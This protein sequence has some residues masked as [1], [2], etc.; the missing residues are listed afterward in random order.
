MPKTGAVYKRELIHLFQWLRAGVDFCDLLRHLLQPSIVWIRTAY[1]Y[2][3]AG[4]SDR[5]VK[6]GDPLSPLL[7]NIYLSVVQRFVMMKYRIW[8][9]SK[10]EGHEDEGRVRECLRASDSD[11]VDVVWDRASLG[12]Y[13][14]LPVWYADNGVLFAGSLEVLSAAV[15]WA[16]EAATMLQLKFNPRKSVLMRFLGRDR[17]SASLQQGSVRLQG[18]DLATATETRWL[19]FTVTDDL[20]LRRH[21]ELRLKAAKVA[22][23]QFMDMGVWQMGVSLRSSCDTVEDIGTTSIIVR[24]GGASCAW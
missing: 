16:D 3:N 24:C 15:S 23:R 12:H 22:H 14:F 8:L 17:T 5:G 4:V 9:L 2:V 19:G 7:F 13:C 18:V 1:G 21:C 10:L 20:R 6:Q 11:H